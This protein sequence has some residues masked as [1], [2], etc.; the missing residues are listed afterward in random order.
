LYATENIFEVVLWYVCI[1]VGSH[2]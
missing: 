2:L 1:V